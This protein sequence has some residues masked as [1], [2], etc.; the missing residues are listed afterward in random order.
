MQFVGNSVCNQWRLYLLPKKI[1]CFYKEGEG[2]IVVEGDGWRVG[3]MQDYVTVYNNSQ[4]V[5]HLANH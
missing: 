1:Y 5:I 2:D 3:V 4:S